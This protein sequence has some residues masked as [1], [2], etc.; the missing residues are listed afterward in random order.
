MDEAVDL[1]EILSQPVLVIIFYSEVKHLQTSRDILIM[2]PNL[3]LVIA[4]MYKI[5]F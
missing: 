2:Y 5:M 3:R 4:T 1:S